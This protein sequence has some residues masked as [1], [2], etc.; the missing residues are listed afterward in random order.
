MTTR[1]MHWRDVRP[2]D[3]VELVSGRHMYVIIRDG[4]RYIAY[5]SSFDAQDA[6]RFLMSKV[7]RGAS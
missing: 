3:E 6:E 5:W 2:T 4:K 1:N 7:G